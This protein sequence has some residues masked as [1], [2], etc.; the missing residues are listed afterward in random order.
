[1]VRR[2]LL[3]VGAI[4]IAALCAR[5]AEAEIRIAVAGADDRR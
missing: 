4:S 3:F 5:A 2:K 1:M